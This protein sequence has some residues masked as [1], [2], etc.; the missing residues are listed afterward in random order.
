MSLLIFKQDFLFLLG[1]SSKSERLASVE[2]HLK[3]FSNALECG[4]THAGFRWLELLAFLFNLISMAH[5]KF[6]IY[7]SMEINLTPWISWHFSKTIRFGN[8]VA[9][10]EPKIIMQICWLSKPSKLLI[11]RHYSRP[12]NTSICYNWGHREQYRKR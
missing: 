9:A 10:I 7:R 3:P 6:M 1:D 5:V 8:K 11:I 12:V 2:W 4:S